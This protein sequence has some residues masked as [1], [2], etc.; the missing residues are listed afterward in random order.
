MAN[1]ASKRSD[2][3]P[4]Q[5]PLSYAS[6]HRRNGGFGHGVKADE[7]RKKAEEYRDLAESATKPYAIESIGGG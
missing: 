5:T 3:D 1:Q 4:S 2:E 6:I 7:F